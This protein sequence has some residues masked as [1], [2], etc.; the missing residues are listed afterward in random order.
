MWDSGPYVSHIRNASCYQ[1]LDYYISTKAP[2]VYILYFPIL[3][4]KTKEL[5]LLKELS[6]VVG[7]RFEFKQSEFRTHTP[8]TFILYFLLIIKKQIQKKLR[9]QRNDFLNVILRESCG[10]LSS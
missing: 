6:E 3:K 1:C 10:Y 2:V 4:M 9:A 5:M 8:L 7:L